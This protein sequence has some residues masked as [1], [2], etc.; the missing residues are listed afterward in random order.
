MLYCF[1]GT[2][3]RFKLIRMRSKGLRET[4][5]LFMVLLSYPNTEGKDYEIYPRDYKNMVCYC[6]L[7]YVD[8][9]TIVILFLS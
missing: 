9:C 2:F 6:W 8:G 5:S 1:L 7:C 4:I 3:R